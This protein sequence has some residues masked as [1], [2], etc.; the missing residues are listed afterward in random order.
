MVNLAPLSDLQVP[1]SVITLIDKE[2]LLTAAEAGFPPVSM[3][4]NVTMCRWEELWAAGRVSTPPQQS[5]EGFCL[6]P[7]LLRHLVAY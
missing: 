1:I 3:D 4:R 6:R 2:K 7:V 5:M